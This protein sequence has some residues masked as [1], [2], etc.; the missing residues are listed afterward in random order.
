M[1]RDSSIKHRQAAK[2]HLELFQA[3][4]YPTQ[5]VPL[6]CGNES[7]GGSL[8]VINGKDRVDVQEFC[9]KGNCS[10]DETEA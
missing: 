10:C 2:D 4:G 8:C 5:A 9:W 7:L 1:S 3:L 6:M